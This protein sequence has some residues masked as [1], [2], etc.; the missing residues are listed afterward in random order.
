VARSPALVR[1]TVPV[2]GGGRATVLT[3][4]HLLPA[5]ATP[6]CVVMVGGDEGEMALSPVWGGGEAVVGAR[7]LQ[8]LVAHVVDEGR[9]LGEVVDAVVRLGGGEGG[10]GE[11]VVQQ[12]ALSALHAEPTWEPVGRPIIFRLEVSDRAA[13][14]CSRS[15]HRIR[16]MCLCARAGGRSRGV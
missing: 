8:M 13:W 15:H 2:E 16:C 1:V 6:T 4:A 9:A 14:L 7:A 3:N 11:L 12:Q 10:G 5:G